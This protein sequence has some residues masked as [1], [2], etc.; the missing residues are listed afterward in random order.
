[1]ILAV[2]ACAGATAGLLVL[3][4]RG[5][6]ADLY[7]FELPLVAFVGAANLAYACY[8]GTL[9]VRAAL[10]RAPSRAAI[11]ALVAANATWVLVCAGLAARTWPTATAFGLAH[12]TLEGLIVGGLAGVE[13]RVVLPRRSCAR[14]L[15]GKVF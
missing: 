8:S 10:G 15:L 12:L 7:G 13:Y 4:L 3:S 9:A 14:A 6:L 1:M 5:W 2:D 11:A